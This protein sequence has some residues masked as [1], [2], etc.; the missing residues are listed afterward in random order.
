MMQAH[1]L[2]FVLVAAWLFAL[3]SG[4]EQYSGLFGQS[5]SRQETPTF[6]IQGTIES[7]WNPLLKGQVVAKDKVTFHAEQ[8]VK[9]VGG[10]NSPYIAVPRTEVRF[11]GDRLEKTVVVDE[12]GFYQ[13]DLPVGVYKMTAEG[14]TIGGQ[15]LTPYVRFFR[16]DSTTKVVLDGALYLAPT[17][18][19]IVVV[20]DTPEEQREEMKDACG[21][22]DSFLLPSQKDGTPF[23]VFFRYPTRELTRYGFAYNGSEKAPVFVAYNLFSLQATEVHYNAKHHTI[24]ALGNVVVEDGSGATRHLAAAHFTFQD[25]VAAEFREQLPRPSE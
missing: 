25:G 14:P 16:V 21:G 4:A 19:D 11:H 18:C 8:A 9:P 12:K 3:T 22:T 6:H 15:G 13:A 1:H 20:T 23:E 24:G 5:V 7:P 17:T 2:R 10:D